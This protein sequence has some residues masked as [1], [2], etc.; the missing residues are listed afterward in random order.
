METQ[1]LNLMQLITAGHSTNLFTSNIFETFQKT[2]PWYSSSV[3]HQ[4]FFFLQIQD[5]LQ[6]RLKCEPSLWCWYLKEMKT[7][8]VD[9]HDVTIKS[10]AQHCEVR[11]KNKTQLDWTQPR[12]SAAWARPRMIYDS[13][14]WQVA[15]LQPHAAAKH[16][17]HS[18]PS[19]HLTSN[20]KKS[21]CFPGENKS[22]SLLQR[23]S[24]F[25][26]LPLSFTVC[27]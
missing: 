18:S 12:L 17:W 5:W 6:P 26:T 8:T 15:L 27:L 4:F 3:A 24:I 2:W 1:P 11:V 14:V 23:I 22:L 20:K 10:D 7:V 21:M 19:L 9:Q 25:Y 16:C 13:E